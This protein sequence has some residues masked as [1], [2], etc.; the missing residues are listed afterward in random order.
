M[1]DRTDPREAPRLVCRERLHRHNAEGTHD[2]ASMTDEQF[3]L[4]TRYFE[5]PLA[6]E[7]LEIV[8]GG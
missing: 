7:G 1:T 6:E 3:D 5:P 4:I 8:W 2:F